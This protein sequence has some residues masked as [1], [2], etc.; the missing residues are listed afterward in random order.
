[1]T[2]FLTY[3]FIFLFSFTSSVKAQV[4][5][6]IQR[7]QQQLIDA[8]FQRQELDRAIRKAPTPTSSY[9]QS[10]PEKSTSTRCVDIREIEVDG[11]TKISTTRIKKIAQPYLNKCLTVDDIN[12]ILNAITNAYIDAGYITSGAYLITPQTKLNDGI[13]QIKIVEG[14]ITKFTGITEA[15]RKTA[16]PWVLGSV[17]N[18][19]DIEQGLDQ[20]NRL[21]SNHAKMEIKANEDANGTS[22]IVITN[23]KENPTSYSVYTD[24]LGSKPTGE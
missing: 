9:I 3:I 17:L 20:M 10:L 5:S 7:Q 18:L 14:T 23:E 15:E 19:R 16:F 12:K 1:M 4:S 8:G 24:N 13:L 11:N 2:K 6:Q 21:S 22:Q